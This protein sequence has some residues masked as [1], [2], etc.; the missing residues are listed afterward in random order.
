MLY[1]IGGVVAGTVIA[2]FAIAL[3]ANKQECSQEQKIR[4]LTSANKTLEEEYHSAQRLQQY[5]RARC[6]KETL[7]IEAVAPELTEAEKK[8]V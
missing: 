6:F 3:V 5:W 4:E 1:F 8:C 7:G 2:T